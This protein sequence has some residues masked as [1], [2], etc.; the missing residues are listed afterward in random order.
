MR[1]RSVRVVVDDFGVGAPSLGR[2]S[3]I[4]PHAL[5]IDGSFVRDL[6]G[7]GGRICRAIVEL[8]H[9][10]DMVTIAEFVEDESTARALL[11]MHCDALQGYGVSKPLP[12]TDMLEWLRAAC[13]GPA[14]GC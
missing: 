1:D 2:V 12:A 3:Q 14:P 13:G 9:E 5:K 10:L 7:K 8:S 4:G 11:A 6:A